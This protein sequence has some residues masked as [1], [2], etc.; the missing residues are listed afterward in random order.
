[1]DKRTPLSHW[2]ET[3]GGKMVSFA[4]FLMPIQ[5]E[6]GILHEHACV[7][8]KAGLF[9][10]SHMGE[11]ICEGKDALKLLNYL[12]SNDFTDLKIGNIRYG[13][14][15]YDHGGAVDDVLIYRLD[16]DAYLWVVNASN[17]EKDFTYI[18]AHLSG[19]V[20]LKNIS[21]NLGEIALQGPLS[22]EILR[23]IT[24]QIP[25]DYYTFKQNVI[26]QGMNVLISRTG[27]TAED[28]FEIYTQVD[29][30][31]KMWSLLLDVGREENL[32]PCGLGARDTLRLEG[33]MPLYGHELSENI[34]A[35]EAGLNRFVKLDKGNFIA[36]E[37]LSKPVLRKRI[38]LELIDRGIARE[39]YKVYL[40]Q[41]EVGV[42][43]SGTHSPTL[44][45]AIA[46]AL[47]NSDSA[48]ENEFEIDVRNR[49][50][51][52]KKVKSPFYRR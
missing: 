25:I 45:K 38:A 1:M 5:Y 10:V 41:V 19:D 50:L 18:Q 40:N 17:I 13:I 8:E 7:R 20:T 43:T 36:Q 44:N 48:Q 15:L 4:G 22:E 42:I 37:A 31:E 12:L 52:A 33:G 21:D 51:K 30:T 46:L 9:D 3:H 47:V 6:L 39:G 26:I 32:I 2:H 28:G 35:L 14:L 11:F 29:D 34:T 49:R 27:Y 23:K 16:E 24:N